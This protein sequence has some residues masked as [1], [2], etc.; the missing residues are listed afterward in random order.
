MRHNNIG[1]KSSLYILGKEFVIVIVVIFS[2]LS[3][4]LGYFVGKSGSDIRQKS[5]VQHKETA[6]VPQSEKT[7]TVQ[8]EK[9]AESSREDV[10]MI[11]QQEPLLPAEAEVTESRESLVS[12]K[13]SSVSAANTEKGRDIVYTVQLGAFKS[14]ADAENFKS[15]YNQKGYTTYITIA[16]NNKN[17]NI[18]KVRMGRF[19]TKEEAESFS[20][21]L[22]KT[23]SLTTFVTFKSD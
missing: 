20:E 3:F 10:V 5:V 1:E 16:K 18:Y 12:E 22:K 8:I 2:A 21:K 14:A 23:E 11:D 6:P 4:T 19:K 9:R 13:E 15:K 7:S 17:E